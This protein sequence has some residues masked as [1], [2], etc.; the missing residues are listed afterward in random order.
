LGLLETT[1]LSQENHARAC[2]SSFTLPS[3][4]AFVSL[5][6]GNGRIIGAPLNKGVDLAGGHNSR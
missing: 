1:R 4:R 2:E 6:S 3:I 5:F